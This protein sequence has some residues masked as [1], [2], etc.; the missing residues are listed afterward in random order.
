MKTAINETLAVQTLKKRRLERE[1]S[2]INQE[3]S[4]FHTLTDIELDNA[5]YLSALELGFE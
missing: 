1:F 2:W 3:F 5:P 4:N